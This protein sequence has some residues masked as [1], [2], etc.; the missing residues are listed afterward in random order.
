MTKFGILIL[1]FAILLMIGCK[2]NSDDTAPEIMLELD[3]WE[4][5]KTKFDL[6]INS[7][8]LFFINSEIG[9]LVGYNG[10]LYK[11]L[12]S[13]KSWIKQ[14]AGTTLHLYSVFFLNENIGFIS[15]EAMI[16]CLD[17]DCDKGSIMLKTTDGG[18]TWTKIFFKNYSGIYC[19]KFFDELRGLAIIHTPHIPNSRDYYIA[20]TN[21]G[22]SNWEL[23]DLKIK[24]MYDKYFWV[25]GIT[26]IAG[27][28]QKLFKSK[29]YGNSWEI[30]NTPIPVSKDIRNIYFYNE[31]IGFLDGVT[32]IYKTTDGGSNWETTEFPFLSFGVFHFYDSNEGFNI[33]TVSVYEGGDSPTFK[34]S[35]SY[36]TMNGGESWKDSE[37]IKSL[38]LGL[39]YFPQ[40][41]LGYGINLSEFYTIKRK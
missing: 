11:T 12:D 9:F 29:D 34:G 15:G 38:H 7:R 39:T 22:G 5:S 16:G 36:Q 32:S 37:L 30:I 31:N 18:K 19:L 35:K 2:K 23:I 14:N 4:I 41:D 24:P 20:R 26:Y 27:E 3:G 6:D 1:L 13:G 28:N 25:D 40:R 21:D 10:A 33:G 8:D 17:N